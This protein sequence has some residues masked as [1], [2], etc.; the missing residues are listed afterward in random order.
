MLSQNSCLPESE[1]SGMTAVLSTKFSGCLLHNSRGLKH[2]DIPTSLYYYYFLLKYSWFVVVVE[3][4]T[5]VW[6][7]MTPWTVA[8]QAPLT[9]GFS[10]QEYWGRLP[11][12]SPGD[13]PNPGI[14]PVFPALAGR[15]FATEPPRKPQ[16]CSIYCYMAKWFSYSFF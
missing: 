5:H 9:I 13:L 8:H 10:R 7:F 11:L 3:L 14:E 2:V 6:L 12:P 4:L 16:Y 1:H 15:F